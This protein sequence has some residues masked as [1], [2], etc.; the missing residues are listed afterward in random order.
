MIPTRALAWR[1]SLSVAH[2]A[3]WLPSAIPDGEPGRLAVQELFQA[4]DFPAQ[5]AQEVR[6]QRDTLG[7]PFVTWEGRVAAW[8]AQRAMHSRHLH[9]SNSHDGEAHLAVAAYHPALVGVGVDI[10]HLPRLRLPGK[11]ATYL[12]RF[13]ARF[14]APIER[15]RF[16][17][18]TVTEE[19]ESLRLRVAAH[20]SLMEAASKAL[21]TGLR[22]GPGMN[23]SYSV[24]MQSLGA[25]RLFPSVEM[26][27]EGMALDRLRFLG[28]VRCEAHWSAC[29]DYLASIV[30]L[31]R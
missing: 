12:H 2:G 11:D 16:L 3:A 21:G 28:A 8:A 13:A 9:V 25:V 10:V 23:K 4:F 29:H 19:E 1:K 22:A 31:W 15:N 30:L 14:L 7:K 5:A 27:F 26:V 24:P 20:F 6:W 18:Q 17:R